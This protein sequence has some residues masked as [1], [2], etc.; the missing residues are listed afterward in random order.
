MEPIAVG[1]YGATHPHSRG[2]LQTL[3]ILTEVEKVSLFDPEEGAVRQSA[4]DFPMVAPADSLESIL[5]DPSLPVVMI[6]RPNR[7]N[8]QAVLRALEAGKHVFTEKPAARSAEEMRA[9]ADAAA[10]TGRAFTVCYPWRYNPIAVDI[11]S[12]IRQGLLGRLV[13]FEARMLTN[14]VRFRNPSHWLFSREESG[15]GILSWLA[16]HWIDLLR[17]LFDSEVTSVCARAVK[18]FDEA[19]TVEDTGCMILSFANGAVGTLR[20][21]YSL[22][23]G[24]DT[25]IGIEGTMGRIAWDPN[26]NASFRI[27]TM[28]ARWGAAPAREMRYTF[29]KAPAYADMWGLNF[30][31]DFL[32]A[33]IGG[34]PYAVR[35]EDAFKTLQVI[36][37]AY[38]ASETG[39]EVRL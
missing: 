8:A 7:E 14:Q 30:V 33:A 19:I 13:S 36:D 24:Y 15:G 3:Q 38:R 21:A 32:H 16:C 37:A 6:F 4:A 5:Q 18:Q 28:D 35:A 29:A 22:P 27:Q 25:Y 12:M 10:R 17:F 39:G 34:K 1:V 11:Q 9:V 23:E 26:E 20:A 31:R 2:Y